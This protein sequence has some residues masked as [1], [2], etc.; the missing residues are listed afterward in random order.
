MYSAACPA[1]ARSMTNNTVAIRFID[2]LLTGNKDSV[3]DAPD[4]VN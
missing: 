1:V 4:R 2:R 3:R